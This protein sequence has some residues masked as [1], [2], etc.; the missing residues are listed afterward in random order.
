MIKL[1]LKKGKIK[2]IKYEIKFIKRYILFKKI[3]L[4]NLKN[5]YKS[6]K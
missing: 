6:K 3:I 4:L 1:N 5:I 2:K